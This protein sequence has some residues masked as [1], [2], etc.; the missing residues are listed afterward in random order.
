MVGRP[1]PHPEAAWQLRMLSQQQML[2]AWLWLTLCCCPLLCITRI[3]SNVAWLQA[4]MGDIAAAHP[5]AAGEG[6]LAAVRPHMAHARN[7]APTQSGAAASAPCHPHH[8]SLLG[9]LLVA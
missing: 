7:T 8:G 1:D 6:R 5:E 2:A 4:S 9:D 3:V